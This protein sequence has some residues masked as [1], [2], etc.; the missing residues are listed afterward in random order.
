MFFFVVG[1]ELKSEFIGGE[2]REMKKVV[3]PIGAAV[4]G[5]I[6][7]AAIYL[8]FNLGSDTTNGWGIPMA[9]DI[10]FALAIIH[11]LGKSVPISAKIFLTTLAIVPWF[12]TCNCIFLHLSNLHVKYKYRIYISTVNVYWQ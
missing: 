8:I 3:L 6:V 10:A 5:M 12:G 7:P 2:L 9:T 4:M 11:V 1:L